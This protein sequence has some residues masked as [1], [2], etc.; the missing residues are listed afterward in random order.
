MRRTRTLYVT[1][2]STGREQWYRIRT[3]ELSISNLAATDGIS[4][5]AW[6]WSEERG[7][8]TNYM[9]YTHIDTTHT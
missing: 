8:K 3:E 7:K 6:L 9:L 5:V 1:H 4:R 2:L